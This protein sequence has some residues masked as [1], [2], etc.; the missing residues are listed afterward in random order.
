[1]AESFG[2]PEC[3]N[4]VGTDL[5]VATGRSRLRGAGSEHG[6][7]R[8][9]CQLYLFLDKFTLMMYIIQYDNCYRDAR[10]NDLVPVSLHPS[11]PLTRSSWGASP[12]PCPEP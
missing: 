7:C 4:L 6:S 10:P 2:E 12:L 3:P 8:S 11:P 1:M 5:V 9:E